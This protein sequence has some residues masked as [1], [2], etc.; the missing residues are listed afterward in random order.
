MSIDKDG[1]R[2]SLDHVYK[3]QLVRTAR[4]SGSA[5]APAYSRR[6]ASVVTVGD[7]RTGYEAC[8]W[9]LDDIYQIHLIG[10][11]TDA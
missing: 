6:A 5:S 3:G 4:G 2:S 1:K 7:P 10:G 9:R 11:R 8:K